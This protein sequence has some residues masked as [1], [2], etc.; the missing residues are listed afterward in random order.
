M[1]TRFLDSV[2]TAIA[3]VLVASCGVHASE[4]TNI[5]GSID[6]S[7][8]SNA[9]L[10]ISDSTS[11]TDFLESLFVM[12]FSK[13]ELERRFGGA[14]LADISAGSLLYSHE[15]GLSEKDWNLLVDGYLMDG[16]LR[17][18]DEKR[19]LGFVTLMWQRPT[20]GIQAFISI[21]KIPRPDFMNPIP[22]Q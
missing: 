1:N 17:S 5:F 18:K 12:G 16:Y 13:D 9:V 21:A 10:A 19:K 2:S 3:V 22:V 14:N 15:F 11:L 8:P 20:A 6:I 7:N 4:N